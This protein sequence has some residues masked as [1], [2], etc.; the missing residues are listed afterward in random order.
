MEL[1]FVG[2]GLFSIF[3]NK[4]VKQKL[5]RNE[6]VRWSKELE[7]ALRESDVI[8]VSMLEERPDILEIGFLLGRRAAQSQTNIIF[9]SNQDFAI[10]V[11]ANNE[12]EA[13]R[14]LV[15]VAVKLDKAN[16]S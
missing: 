9:S 2:P 15:S 3:E 8:F 11:F 5:N 14:K 13:V 1:T 6:P 16:G 10:A 4:I 12:K 7:D